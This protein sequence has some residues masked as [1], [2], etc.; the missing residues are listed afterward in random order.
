MK[1]GSDVATYDSALYTGF[2]VVTL[3]TIPS[4]PITREL[5][6]LLPN[7]PTNYAA[8]IECANPYGS[9][10]FECENMEFMNGRLLAFSFGCTTTNAYYKLAGIPQAC[11]LSVTGHCAASDGSG[12]TSYTSMFSFTPST[13]YGAPMKTVD[14][15]TASVPAGVNGNSCA[16]YTFSAVSPPS[17][18]SVPVTLALGKLTP[19]RI[20]C[21]LRLTPVGA[22]TL[23]Y[24]AQY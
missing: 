19:L 16:N 13:I 9:L 2:T 18:S 23:I 12:T 4:M 3:E 10:A 8:T 22:D 11:D 6:A 14:F 7:T 17:A 5:P 15:T 24:T 20:R 21:R 1:T